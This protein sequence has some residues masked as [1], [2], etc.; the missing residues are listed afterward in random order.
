MIIHERRA[1]NEDIR[2]RHF[3]VVIVMGA[4]MEQDENGMFYFP[5]FFEFRNGK[6]VDGD[7]RARAIKVI[8]DRQL[9]QFVIVT[10]GNED[11]FFPVTSRAQ[12]L[13]H[14]AHTVYGVPKERMYQMT[15]VGKS[16]K[17]IESAG[18]LLE[19]ANGELTP[20]NSVAFLTNAFHIRRTAAFV[21]ADPF[22]GTHPELAIHYL[23]AEGLLVQAGLLSQE[24]AR[25][26]YQSLSVR[27]RQEN[28]GVEDLGNN[29]YRET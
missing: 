9:A 6:L 15:T 18:K 19:L 12:A 23:S 2:P 21:R 25:E 5:R 27:I 17:N 7:L 10:G 26:Y 14:H 11:T 3:D 28:Q 20:N 16:K 4:Q 8:N 13:I 24:E 29:K 1:G 22:F